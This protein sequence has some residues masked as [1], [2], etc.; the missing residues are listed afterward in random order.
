LRINNIKLKKVIM[1]T[2]PNPEL[3][4]GNPSWLDQLRLPDNY[5]NIPWRGKPDSPDAPRYKAMGN[6]MAVPVMAWIG[7]RIQGVEDEQSN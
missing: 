4:N 6:S 1:N 2:T 7:K 3:K 5:T